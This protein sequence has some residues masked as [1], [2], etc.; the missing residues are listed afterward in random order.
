M[1]NVMLVE[2][3]TVAGVGQ[4]GRTAM[5][6]LTEA[7]DQATTRTA[8]PSRDVWN[9]FAHAG[10]GTLAGRYM[11]RFWHPVYRSEDLNPGRT[12]PLRIMSEDLT[13]Y[14]GDSG[15]VHALAFRCAHRG[16]QLSTGWVEGDT[17]RCFYH[18]WRYDGSGQCVEQPAEPEPFC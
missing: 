14:R 1:L 4:K 9:D 12:V 15:T 8:E 5:N 6:A 11:R 7:D 10:P 18:G 13:L 3:H 16:T 2:I 17:L